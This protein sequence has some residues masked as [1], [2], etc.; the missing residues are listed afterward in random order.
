VKISHLFISRPVMT[1]VL[2]LAILLGGIVGY[3]HLPVDALPK[4]DFP[5]IQ[6]SATLPGASPEQ[7]AA[8]VAT[9]LERQFSTIAGVNSMSSTNAQGVTQITL[10]FDLDRDIDAAAQ[11]VQAAISEAMRRLPV[12]M[13]VPPS[14][15]KVNPADS[16]V[17]VLTIRSDTVPLNTVFEYADSA[18]VPN[19]ATLPGV[20]Q[21]FIFGAQKYAV[22]VQV[23]PRELAARGI[24][25]DQVRQAIGSVQVNTPVGA[26]DRG[27]QAFTLT[28]TNQMH[29]AAEFREVIIAWRGGAPVRLKD[30][31][32]VLDGV[33]TDRVNSWY[34]GRRAMGLAVYRQPGA[35]TVQVVNSVKALMPQFRALLPPS[36]ELDV[37]IDRTLSIRESIR[38]V[39][40][41]L[42]FTVVLVV[43]V[44]F[45][46]LRDARA[47]V[48][49]ALAVPLSIVGTFA[50]MYYMGYSLN[51]LSLMALTVAVG[52]VVDDAV[53]MLENIYRH[54]EMG[55][56]RLSASQHGS[57]EVGFTIISMT[58]S[59]IAVFIPL[60]FM[61]GI[62]GRLF[63]E[64][65]V[66][67]TI[68]IAISGVVSLT[69]TPMLCSLF[70][71]AEHERKHGRIY[72]ASE[73]IF[74][75]SLRWY[76]H[77]L[78]VSMA[79]PR[80]MLAL[81]LVTL[82]GTIQLVILMPKG[83]LPV[84]DT[85]QIFMFT[86][87]TQDTAFP[88]M[89]RRQQE[90]AAIVQKNPN[91]QGVFSSVGGG[92]IN[93]TNNTGRIFATLKPAH[94]RKDG[95]LDVIQQ[96]RGAFRG[97]VGINVYPQPIQNIRIGG[98]ITRT[99]YQYTLQSSN[100]EELY[101]TAQ[102]A[103]DA[104]RTIPLL[105]DVASDMQLS[106]PKAVV[107]IDRDAAARLEVSVAQISDALY[108]AYGQRQVATIYGA[109]NQYQVI[110]EVQPEFQRNPGDLSDIHVRSATGRLV[111]LHAVATVEPAAGP[112]TVNHQGQLPSVT[113]SFNLAPGAA[114]GDAVNAIREMERQL[115]FPATLN[116]S[117]QGTAQ[118][119]QESL[120]T[121][122]F[123]IAVAVV[124]IY[125][126]LAM[127]Y[128]SFIHPITILSGLPSAAVGACLPLLLFGVDLNVI[129]I[130]GIV[131]LVGIVKKNAIMMVD[132]ALHAERSEGLPPVEAIRKAC[133]LRFRPIMMTTMAAIMGVL[134][135]ALGIGAGS[136]L[137]QPLGLAVVG[138]L[139][140]SQLLTL[141]ITPVIYLY[142]DKLRKK[143]PK[144]QAEPEEVEPAL[145]FPI[146]ERVAG[147]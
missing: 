147:D 29:S 91:V 39:Q 120:A 125:M 67:M 81:T 66:T 110:L 41:T 80:T 19:I 116:T 136:E 24:G 121:Q 2:M 124:V 103:F 69:L 133:L 1:T 56:E 43:L 78:R 10:Q 118:A 15:R 27:N 44:I 89:A 57:R 129:A 12:E 109:T 132:F 134:P 26:L 145:A 139:V 123:L 52:F 58:V 31:A 114:L 49:P 45:F 102:R 85:G 35:N 38:D 141:F 99:L 108:S 146:R 51:N 73:A 5:T 9:P 13:T 20:A 64:F 11:D 84:E 97:L 42:I 101:A 46:F 60:L 72:R 68:A 131:M 7:M 28:M 87:A 88:A 14:F 71:H 137:R 4:V 21:V 126:I 63:R 117:F 74:D 130:I 90:A 113:L 61:G 93:A 79:H 83:F 119:F 138:G 22:R 98:R 135:I 75:A 95:I 104:M 96:L 106:A 55:K 70:L 86:E 33:E 82:Y 17:L 76:E 62:I 40:L 122:A 6:V 3:R 59:L 100:L 143:P 23:D 94:D 32:E 128:E 127:L 142:L 50:G 92:T 34:N 77:L 47:T 37:V 30:V 107:R 16:P 115:R 18:I 144:P 25:L 105:Q 48:I 112:L 111:P 54:L 8:S 65:A 140:V 53:V 36:I